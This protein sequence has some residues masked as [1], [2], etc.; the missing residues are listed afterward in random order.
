MDESLITVRYAK[1]FFSLAKEK[2]LLEPLK[3]DIE[4]IASVC[5]KSVEFNLLLES[6]I[7]KASKKT[8]IISII[9]KGHIHELTLRFLALVTENKRETHIPG[10]CRNFLALYRKGQG[11]KSAT[12]TTASKISSATLKKIQAVMEKEFNTKIELTEKVN[13]SLI[14]GMILRVDDK[15]LDASVAT[16]LKK[17]KT[18]FLE[19]EI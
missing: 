11:I 16:Q 10:I 3:S 18:K 17:I 2:Q 7:V 12:V 8:N 9:F 1:A 4:A 19:T 14:G 5:N 6:P 15:Q 13:P